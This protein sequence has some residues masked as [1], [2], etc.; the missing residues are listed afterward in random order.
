MDQQFQDTLYFPPQQQVRPNEP[1]FGQTGSQHADP[2]WIL[3]FVGH[4]YHFQ[5]NVLA[6]GTLVAPGVF[7]TA[8]HV[9]D[10]INLAE[11]KVQ[12]PGLGNESFSFAG[13]LEDGAQLTRPQDYLLLQVRENT[14]HN[15]NGVQFLELTKPIG[16]FYC[17]TASLE[18]LSGENRNYGHWQYL[19]HQS[20]L[21]PSGG[22]SGSPYI[23]LDAS[24]NP[25]IFGLHARGTDFGPIA[26][27]GRGGVSLATIFHNHQPNHLQRVFNC[28]H[29]QMPERL[30]PFS[31]PQRRL[32]GIR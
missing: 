28:H 20:T 21:P 13:I 24:H 9:V 1:A 11:L 4:L 23:Y 19:L 12:F 22:C 29:L 25:K 7:L 10:Q 3:D 17:L 27:G 5:P 26:G 8:R 31:P 30:A 2:T 14:Y 6:L 16:R 15:W 18:W 32:R